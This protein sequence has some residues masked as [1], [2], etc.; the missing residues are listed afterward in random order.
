MS[1]GLHTV[2]STRS[3]EDIPHNKKWSVVGF[4]FCYTGL[5]KRVFFSNHSSSRLRVHPTQEWHDLYQEDTIADL[6]K[7]RDF[8]M[9]GIQNDWEATPSARISIL[10]F[11]KVCCPC[12][13]L[14]CW[15]LTNPSSHQS[16]TSHFQTG[17]FLKQRTRSSISL[18]KANS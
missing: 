17:L 9:K 16:R 13:I 7:F 2:G 8:Y 14:E 3:Y 11:N 1:T 18:L 6:K 15:S 12:H 5:I 4:S 10:R